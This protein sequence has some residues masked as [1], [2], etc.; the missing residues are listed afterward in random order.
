MLQDGCQDCLW[1]LW[2]LVLV[3]VLGCV[4][5]ACCWQLAP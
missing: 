3:L 4:D 2:K 1:Q 5:L